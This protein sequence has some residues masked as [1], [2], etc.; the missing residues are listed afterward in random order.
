MGYHH[1]K[2][3]QIQNFPCCNRTHQV[4]IQSY[5]FGIDE[6]LSPAIDSPSNRLGVSTQSRLKFAWI[7]GQMFYVSLACLIRQ[8]LGIQ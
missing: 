3:L 7:T 2:W 6:D 8:L 5:L 1:P 4:R